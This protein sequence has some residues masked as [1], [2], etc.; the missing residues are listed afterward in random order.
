MARMD[1]AFAEKAEIAAGSGAAETLFDLGM[2]YCSGRDV[3]QDLVSAHKWFNL[4]ALRGSEEARQ[5]RLEISQEMTTDEIAAAQRE[6]RNWM[7][8]N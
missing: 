1:M 3:V 6:A 2:M 5:H 7:A 8:T 4:A